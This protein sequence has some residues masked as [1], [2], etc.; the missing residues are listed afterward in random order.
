MFLHHQKVLKV[1]NAGSYSND[2]WSLLIKRF[3]TKVTSKS[4]L[5][6]ANMKISSK[7]S[8]IK[9]YDV[10]YITELLFS[11]TAMRSPLG[12]ALANII[13][14]SFENKWL[15][16]ALMLWSLSPKDGILMTYLYCFLLSIMQKSL[17]SI[18]LPNIPTWIICL[19]K[20]MMVAYLF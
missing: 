17:K 19:R 1:V 6:L 5:L 3:S 7:T 15:K 18:Y 14:C 8:L 20:K 9:R 10:F 4:L 12:V 16:I 2:W 13:I 11:F